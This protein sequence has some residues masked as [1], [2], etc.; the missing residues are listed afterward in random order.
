MPLASRARA[1]I[2]L[3]TAGKYATFHHRVGGSYRGGLSQGLANFTIDKKPVPPLLLLAAATSDIA[4]TI[5]F[6]R[7]WAMALPISVRVWN[8][9]CHRGER[10][11]QPPFV[12]VN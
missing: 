4:F 9:T 3:R 11:S 5:Y 10:D 2:G 1:P 6:C 8:D 7:P 12:S